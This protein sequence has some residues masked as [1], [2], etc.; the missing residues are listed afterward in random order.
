MPAMIP[1]IWTTY[2]SFSTKD[3]AMPIICAISSKSSLFGRRLITDIGSAI[4]DF[5]IHASLDSDHAAR[6]NLRCFACIVVSLQG[7]RRDFNAKTFQ[8]GPG[9]CWQW[10]DRNDLAGNRGLFGF[11]IKTISNLDDLPGADEI[12]KNSPNLIVSSQ[13]RK[14]LPQ[15]NDVLLPGNP[16]RN[17]I[18]ESFVFIHNET[19]YLAGKNTTCMICKNTTLIAL[20]QII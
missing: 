19:N 17:L 10:S 14:I 2:Q 1:I 4:S 5:A 9:Q 16:C 7:G 13:V 8:R 12:S 18:A 3:C 15:E 11:G 6:R 20:S